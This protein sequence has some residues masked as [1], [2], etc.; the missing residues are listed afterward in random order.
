MAE[1]I[2]IRNK[3]AGFEYEIL[4]K[5]VAG[6]Q[7][8]GT[9]IKSIRMG[10]AGISEAWCT[11]VNGE[12]YVREMHIAEY[13]WGSFNNHD[14]KRERKL[15]LRKKEISKLMRKSQEKGFSIIA[16]CLFVNERGLAKLEIALA[17]GKK[18][19]DK[20]EDLRLKDSKRELDRIRKH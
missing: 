9:E 17:R 15:L 20:R 19:Y 4:E 8:Q 14:P 7:L 2:V 11:F 18:A 1:K 6:I 5:F 12:L 13:W 10:K 16:T 3:K